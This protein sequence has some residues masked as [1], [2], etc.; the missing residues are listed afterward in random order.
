MA[1]AL[2][3][4]WAIPKLN[5]VSLLLVHSVFSCSVTAFCYVV[6]ISLTVLVSIVDVVLAPWGAA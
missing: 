3:A 5:F 4:S 1:E 6:L 2:H